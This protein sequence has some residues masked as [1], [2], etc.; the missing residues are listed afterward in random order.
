MSKEQLSLVIRSIYNL[1]ELTMKKND[2]VAIVNNGINSWHH[3]LT[4]FLS[5][6]C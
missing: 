3:Y 2:Q 1:I 4:Y 6:K 5:E